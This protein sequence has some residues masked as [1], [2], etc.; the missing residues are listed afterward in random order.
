[1]TDSARKALPSLAAEIDALAG[2]P[3][4]P[5]VGSGAYRY[6]R[7]IIRGIAELARRRAEEGLGT[8]LD[9][10]PVSTEG[11]DRSDGLSPAEAYMEGVKAERERCAALAEEHKAAYPLDGR[12]VSLNLGWKPQLRDFAD[13]IR[14]S[15]NG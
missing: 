5:T 3:R 6:S 4:L 15:G 11:Q 2:R 14:E 12:W 8:P 13:L 1:M 10:E 9:A 7:G